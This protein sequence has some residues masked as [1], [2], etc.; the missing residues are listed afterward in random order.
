MQAFTLFFSTRK[1]DYQQTIKVKKLSLKKSSPQ[2]V[3]SEAIFNINRYVTV[4]F[5]T[6]LFLQLKLKT[7]L[8]LFPFLP[9]PTQDS[10]IVKA[11]I[12]NDI[13]PLMK[14]MFFFPQC[15]FSFH[16]TW[17][18]S[19]SDA[20]LFSIDG[21][22]AFYKKPENVYCANGSLTIPAPQCR[23]ACSPFWRRNIDWAVWV[24]SSIKSADPR[25]S[26]H[27]EGFSWIT[28]AL[29]HN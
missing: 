19:F 6:Y 11:F 3:L 17:K 22:N 5:Y 13:A 12:R 23:A 8:L 18:K 2:N 16:I 28:W 21:T 20:I 7:L 10:I 4:K 27:Y 25:L 26:L 15:I 24:N 29:H 9:P 14:K 1:S